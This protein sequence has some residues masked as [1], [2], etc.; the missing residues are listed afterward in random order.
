MKKHIIKIF[1]LLIVFAI[2]GCYTIIWTPDEEFPTESTTNDY[3]SE[4]YYGDYYSF[5]DY[6]WWL[7][8]VPPSTPA[9]SEYIRD[10]NG[11]TSSVRN[12]GQGRSNTDRTNTHNINSP[13]RDV[14]NTSS[15]GNTSNS[16][17]SSD[18]SSSVNSSNNNSNTRS[19]DNN[20]V[21]NNDGNRNTNSG[22][23]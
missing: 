7:S 22:R 21:R 10:K 17:T 4:T 20:S 16:S 14:S 18:N 1:T 19:S 2:N 6:P 13:T 15:S 8:Y 12:E 5:Y 11:S 23:R 3:Y 9:G